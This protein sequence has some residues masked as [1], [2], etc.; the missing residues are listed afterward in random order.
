VQDSK[1]ED[2]GKGGTEGTLR[3]KVRKATKI[4][5]RERAPKTPELRKV[6]KGF[7]YKPPALVR[8]EETT[9][10]TKPR[11][12]FGHRHKTGRSK[13][14]GGEK[15]SKNALAEAPTIIRETLN[16]TCRK[17]TKSKTYQAGKDPDRGSFVLFKS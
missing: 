3:G 8:A 10:P 16:Q 17:R 13:R 2:L 7:A 4:K 11:R 14:R 6:S 9:G 5:R 15:G 1:T 12:K